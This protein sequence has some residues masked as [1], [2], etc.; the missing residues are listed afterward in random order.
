[1]NNKSVEKAGVY[2]MCYK[3][4]MLDWNVVPTSYNEQGVD[5]IIYDQSIDRRHRKHTIEVKSSPKSRRIDVSFKDFNADYLVICLLNFFKKETPEIRICDYDQIQEGIKNGDIT[6]DK[7]GKYH[8]HPRHYRE[9]KGLE[10]IG[11]GH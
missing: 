7:N 10:L 4:S 6:K 3:L 1:M 8:I 11:K 9:W 5:I 2:Y